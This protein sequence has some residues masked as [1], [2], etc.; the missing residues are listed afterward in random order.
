MH[1]V[2][3]MALLCA[4]CVLVLVAFEYSAVCML[5]DPDEGAIYTTGELYT[6]PNDFLPSKVNC[7]PR[8][9]YGQ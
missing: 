1:V 5:Q 3:R 4:A 6:N 7:R 9:L 2:P 8:K